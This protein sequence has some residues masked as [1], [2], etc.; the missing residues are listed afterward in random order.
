[1]GS[2]KVEPDSLAGIHLDGAGAASKGTSSAASLYYHPHALPVAAAAAAVLLL[3][4][5]LLCCFRRSSSSPNGSD[6]EH[7]PSGRTMLPAFDVEGGSSASGSNGNARVLH[8]SI[9]VA[10]ASGDVGTL[11][12]W[13]SDD[14]C[15]VD[16]GLAA[17][18]STALHHGARG[19]HANI[20]R[21]LLDH[22]ADC[23]V[24]DTE[25][26]T[27]LHHVAAHGHG[28]ASAPPRTSTPRATGAASL[29]RA[30]GACGLRPV[31]FSMLLLCNVCRG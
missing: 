19:G 22:G 29:L 25:L 26:K 18:G 8:P 31:A 14:R 13:L 23:L 15:V 2:L 1:M 7:R 27:P 30:S 4:L 6:K 20:L 17:D 5:L 10:A 28:Y 16:A 21:L 9:S 24:V 12:T 3:V 11:R